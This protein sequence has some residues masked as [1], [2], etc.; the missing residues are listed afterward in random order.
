MID[1]LI[2]ARGGSKSVPRK[3]I[4]KIHGIPLIAFTIEIAK[5]SKLINNVY[6]STDCSEIAAISEQ[7]G[8]KVPYL[9]ASHLATDN[10]SDKEVF[11][12]FSN[13]MS[14]KGLLISDKILHLRA[15]T[16][17]RD[18]KVV[19]KAINDFN[20]SDNYTSLRSAHKSDHVPEK[21]F[22]KN[23][24]IFTPLFNSDVDTDIHNMPRQ[25]FSTVYIPNG[26]V[27]IVD[28]EKLLKKNSFHGNAIKAFITDECVDI[29]SLEDLKNAKDDPLV[30]KLSK[31]INYI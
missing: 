6:V 12:D 20:K 26:Y 11:I 4:I 25:N 28:L 19:E 18:I 27:D 14:K 21:W 8:A 23:N 17:G 16:P 5:R 22:R 30:I 31:E 3:N 13:Q 15:T 9:R 7:Y 10:A 29:D 1:C 2:P 24:E